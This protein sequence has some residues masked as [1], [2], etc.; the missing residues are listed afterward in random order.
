[1]DLVDY[2]ESSSEA[3]QENDL[4]LHGNTSRH[5]SH[6]SPSPDSIFNGSNHSMNQSL[7]RELSFVKGRLEEERDKLKDWEEQLRQREERLL[8]LEQT[9]WEAHK[10][11]DSIASSEVA[12]RWN[13]VE[14][15]QGRVVSEL[16]GDLRE[17][18]QENNRLKNSF[19]YVRQGNDVLRQQVSDLKSKNDRLEKEIS[20]LQGRITSL[21]RHKVD[22][23]HAGSNQQLSTPDVCLD[24][25]TSS[26]SLQTVTSR[27][28]KKRTSTGLAISQLQPYSDSL[29]ITLSWLTDSTLAPAQT[30]E[31]TPVKLSLRVTRLLTSLSE[32]MHYFSSLS[33]NHELVLTRF[34][35]W[36][37]YHYRRELDNSNATNSGATSLPTTLRR[38]GEEC[39]SNS[40][41]GS[42]VK[43]KAS[44][45]TN[46]FLHSDSLEVRLLSSVIILQTISQADICSHAY[47]LLRN[48]LTDV[49]AR[50]ILLLLSNSILTLLL[51]VVDQTP[52][53]L[54]FSLALC[55]DHFFRYTSHLITEDR[56]DD[57]LKEK[58]AVILQRLSKL[59]HS[60][61]LFERSGL[62]HSC[63]ELLRRL[64]PKRTFLKLNIESVLANLALARH[65]S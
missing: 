62:E 2:T 43:R 24:R 58:L 23:F 35:Y 8:S 45:S 47:D 40:S 14:E 11:L 61:K 42:S 53:S 18:G 1:M 31:L 19:N 46:L 25:N 3:D 64:D 50:E 48:E 55:S 5:A 10:N 52:S 32:L 56:L 27:E 6:F 54:Q 59:P 63:E 34:C 29:F 51:L 41:K 28:N 33:P 22:I 44:E 36:S 16:R 49:R 21:K 13:E 65:N 38:I 30:T 57:A 60:M 12:K 37:I 20:S 17:K 9:A 39:T 4:S 7:V 26:R 15:S